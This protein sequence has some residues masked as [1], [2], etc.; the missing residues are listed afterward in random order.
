MSACKFRAFISY[1]HEDRDVAEWLHR[2]LEGYSVPRELV[3]QSTAKGRIPRKLGPIFIDRYELIAGA[4]SAQIK[5][6][7]HASEHLIVVC[8][9]HSRESKYVEKEI[10]EFK[11]HG[12]AENILALIDGGPSNDHTECFPGALRHTEGHP[13]KEG[14][15]GDADLLA[16]NVEADGRHLAT[17]KIVAGLLGLGLD[18]LRRRD[19]VAERRKRRTWAA[20]AFTMSVLAFSAVGLALFAQQQKGRAE[21]NLRLADQRHEKSI[22]IALRF[23]KSI[24]R[25]AADLHIPSDS[26]SDLLKEFERVL[27][28]LSTVAGSQEIAWRIKAEMEL[29]QAETAARLSNA[30]ERERHADAARE[31]YRKLLQYQPE[32]T[33]YRRGL[34]QAS[35]QVG[36]ALREQGYLAD[37]LTAFGEARII[38][39]KLVA[40]SFAREGDAS[41]S[42]GLHRRDLSGVLLEMGIVLRRQGEIEDAL[43]VLNDALNMRREIALK[44]I[45]DSTAALDVTIALVEYADALGIKGDIREQVRSL[46]RRH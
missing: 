45:N 28:D 25:S 32:S 34:G 46:G 23:A 39:S 44:A 41:A 17:L 43:K 21:A 16:A 10:A 42:V 1:S 12:R 3:G 15:E 6:A 40:E 13:S 14:N 4:L 22:L 27:T 8:T 5:A 2:T 18:E 24:A 31:A 35:F 38:H 30:V 36:F 37:A 26:A 19:A 33:E 9:P 29:H 20:V 7:L 11:S